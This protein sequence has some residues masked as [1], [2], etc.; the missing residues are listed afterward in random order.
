MPVAPD[1]LLAFALASLFLLV[2][3]GPT[4]LLVIGQ[5]LAHGPGVARAAVLGVGLGDLCAASLSI[6]G[7]GTILAASATLFGLVKLAGAA[8]LVWLGIA[9]WRARPELP[10]PGAAAALPRLPEGRIFRDAFLVTLLNPKG[11]LFFM[12]FVPQFVRADAPFLPQAAV[13]VSVFVGLGIL[14][15]WAYAR[16]AARARSA[17]RRPQLLRWAMRAGGSLLVGAGVAAAFARRA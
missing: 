1:T 4:I 17:V 3:P 11:I 13:L 7:I 16:L 2:I 5:A 14:N 10:D 8:W 12:A 9:M 6:A 15:A